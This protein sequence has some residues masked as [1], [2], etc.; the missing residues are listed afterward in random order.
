MPRITPFSEGQVWREKNPKS[1]YVQNGWF[2]VIQEPKGRI[3]PNEK[4][5]IMRY[6]PYGPNMHRG[7]HH[8]YAE[9]R[10]HIFSHDHIKK[11]AVPLDRA[12]YLK[13]QDADE[14]VVKCREAISEHVGNHP[15]MEYAKFSKKMNELE[16]ACWKAWGE[17]HKLIMGETAWNE[18]HEG[19]KWYQETILKA[20]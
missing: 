13:A 20:A 15:Y 4:T 16:V 5:V 2:W 14:K 10:F 3:K 12:I 19:D 11:Y 9:D 18:L 8:R 6:D 7:D 1:P 17:Y